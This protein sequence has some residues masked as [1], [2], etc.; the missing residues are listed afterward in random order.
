MQGGQL[1]GITSFP[2]KYPLPWHDSDLRAA[3]SSHSA[4]DRGATEIKQVS[5]TQGDNIQLLCAGFFFLTLGKSFR[6]RA[7]EV[8]IE[9][10]QGAAVWVL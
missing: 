7:G 10:K 4:G 9:T 6:N 8:A 1:V 2:E 5:R 3:N